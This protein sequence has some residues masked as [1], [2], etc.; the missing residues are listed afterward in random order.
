MPAHDEDAVRLSEQTLL[1]SELL[2]SDSHRVPTL[3][4][5]ALVQPNGLEAGFLESGCC[6]M[7]GSFGYES[8]HYDLR[9]RLANGFCCPACA[10]PNERR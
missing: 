2:V 5:K 10:K 1:L 8:E 4:R 6:E 3:R 7:A 9:C